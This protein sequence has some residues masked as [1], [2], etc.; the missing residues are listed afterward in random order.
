VLSWALEVFPMIIVPFLIGFYHCALAV[1]LISLLKGEV[2]KFLATIL[3]FF[4]IVS[5]NFLS[6]FFVL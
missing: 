6:P 3:M 2:L 4:V 1:F 5:A